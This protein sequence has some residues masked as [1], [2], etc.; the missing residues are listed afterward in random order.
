MDFYVK[1]V[2]FVGSVNK[3]IGSTSTDKYFYVYD[4]VIPYDTFELKNDQLYRIF[5]TI[6]LDNAYELPDGE[7]YVLFP[8]L[9]DNGKGTICVS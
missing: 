2:R 1:C 7:I 6:N 3:R 8:N 5:V 9:K 4:T